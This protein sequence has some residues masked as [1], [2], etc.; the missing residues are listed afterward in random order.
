MRKGSATR[1]RILEIAEAAV[2]AKGFGATSIEELIVEA[3]ITK[4]GFFYHFKDKNELAL[5]LLARHAEQT[6]ALFRSSF[7]RGR[8]LGGDDPLHGLLIGLRLL[9][10]EMDALPGGHPGCMVAAMSYQ[11]R[12]F[13]RDVRAV[14]ATSTENLVDYFH[15]ILVEVAKVHPPRE[16]TDLR[17]LALAICCVIDGGIVIDKSLGGGAGVLPAQIRMLATQVRFIFEAPR[18]IEVVTRPDHIRAA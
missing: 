4:S 2:L 17:Q 14:V 15:R 6:D 8:E 1:E 18:P 11:D 13:D 9:A 5:G 16:D 7:G 3:G 10:E 12:L